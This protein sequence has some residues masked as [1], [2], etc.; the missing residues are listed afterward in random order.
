[1][2]EQ[3]R[4]PWVTLGEVAQRKHRKDPKLDLCEIIWAATRISPFYQELFRNADGGG[5]LSIFG[6]TKLI[7]PSLTFKNLLE[8]Y[9]DPKNLFT[10]VPKILSDQRNL[11][12]EPWLD[13]VE[14]VRQVD[15][16]VL[17]PK[18]AAEQLGIGLTTLYERLK[19]GRKIVVLEP[20]VLITPCKDCNH[21]TSD[22]LH[23]DGSKGEGCAKAKAPAHKC[24]KVNTWLNTNLKRLRE[25]LP[26]ENHPI[27]HETSW[28]DDIKDYRNSVAEVYMAEKVELP[29]AR[30]GAVTEYEVFLDADSGT[31]NSP[32]HAVPFLKASRAA[33]LEHLETIPP[34]KLA[35]PREPQEL[36]PNT[37]S[38]GKPYNLSSEDSDY[39]D[40][41]FH[42]P[43]IPHDYENDIRFEVVACP[44]LGRRKRCLKHKK[45]YGPYKSLRS[46]CSICYEPKQREK[47]EGDEYGDISETAV[48]EVMESYGQPLGVAEAIKGAGRCRS[49]ELFKLWDFEKNDFG[50]MI[51]VF[52]DCKRQPGSEYCA[53]CNQEG[54]KEFRYRG[55]SPNSSFKYAEKTPILEIDEYT[56]KKIQQ[57]GRRR[58]EN[59]WIE[60]MGESQTKNQKIVK[61]GLCFF[62]KWAGHNNEEKWGLNLRD[63]HE[64][65]L[66]LQRDYLRDGYRI[67]TLEPKIGV[68]DITKTRNF[69]WSPFTENPQK[70]VVRQ[71]YWLDRQK[72]ES[73]L[74]R[75]YK[76]HP[77]LT[78][79]KPIGQQ[80][81]KE[82]LPS[83]RDYITVKEKLIL[84]HWLASE[85]KL[86]NWL[87]KNN[88][89][90]PEPFGAVVLPEVFEPL[91]PR[92]FVGGA[93]KIV[94]R[95]ICDSGDFCFKCPHFNAPDCLSQQGLQ[96]FICA[97][98]Y[99]LDADLKT[100]PYKNT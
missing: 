14:A 5:I 100:I 82:F 53:G 65:Q 43:R 27:T 30:S 46:A 49:L 42:Y 13:S 62:P 36:Y 2:K 16:E 74:K 99:C 81:M 97:S 77:V 71:R 95:S 98:F 48:A 1:L 29:L 69:F 38:W 63:L 73:W 92:T 54:P 7:D 22:Y 86:E 21:L 25:S 68:G 55:L 4:S 87:E 91:S 64:R 24:E 17:S 61:R 6:L 39:G 93:Y 58:C 80:W 84:T 19:R 57:E 72:Y 28:D 11:H 44:I 10:L 85:E 59:L 37:D 40:D 26:L 18:D 20:E 76:P 15:I 50:K 35:P 96:D 23:L 56:E 51:S 94:F 66:A 67:K 75:W 52:I 12:K 41:N 3:E 31:V 90:Y 34:Y 89:D 45:R 83:G 47:S 32:I 9:P 79:R 88:M 78:R 33:T 70:E 60:M 8:N